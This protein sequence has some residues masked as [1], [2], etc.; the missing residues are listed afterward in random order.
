MGIF[1]MFL[2]DD[3]KLCKAV[4]Y[5]K[6]QEAQTLLDN[7]ADV[8][9]RFKEKHRSGRLLIVEPVI[10]NN[11]KTVKLLLSY[12]ADA[13]SMAENGVDEQLIS[14]A[15]RNN[16]LEMVKLL[17]SHGANIDAKNSDGE[18]AL[19]IA[20]SKGRQNIVDLLSQKLSKNSA[21]TPK[22]E[23][24][25]KDIDIN[26]L[27]YKA[28]RD[29]DIELVK[30]YLSQG[31]DVNAEF[32][33]VTSLLIASYQDYTE[34]VKLLIQHGADVN[35][36][37]ED[38]SII[39][40]VAFKEQ[41]NS[42]RILLENGAKVNLD[43]NTLQICIIEGKLE[44]VKVFLD[45]NIHINQKLDLAL[46]MANKAGHTEVV[47][48][49]KERITSTETPTTVVQKVTETKPEP[50]RETP[51]KKEIVDDLLEMISPE[52]LQKLEAEHAEKERMHSFESNMDM[53]KF[54]EVLSEIEEEIYEMPSTESNTR[55]TV[56][57]QKTAL[58]SDNMEVTYD[59]LLH[60]SKSMAHRKE[61]GRI[62]LESV[63]EALLHFRLNDKTR[64]YFSNYTN[65]SE[66]EKISN[67]IVWWDTQG[68]IESAR[69]KEV[70]T[71]D[72]AAKKFMLDLLVAFGEHPFGTYRKMG[73]HP[74]WLS[75]E[76]LLKKYELE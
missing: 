30:R 10:R 45:F 25:Q 46:N 58:Q 60:L 36:R 59:D 15:V 47:A 5:G 31:A 63:F 68:S 66:I 71:L 11:L 48:L 64:N 18:T 29:G 62:D 1:G 41:A 52:Y 56:S 20:K 54:N 8:N 49:L 51:P 6:Q 32:D 27:L 34:I 17:L 50:K 33:K 75:P 19:T 57:K 28:S 40:G 44:V 14:I 37:S 2:S 38:G 35:Y 22:T 26:A 21:A 24:K 74:E 13:S 76:E 39:H 70:L 53:R 42:V 55:E 9:S 67:G 73:E 72:N 16:N 12:G 43:E 3:E 65:I 23:T 61:K 7:G 4:D 69:K